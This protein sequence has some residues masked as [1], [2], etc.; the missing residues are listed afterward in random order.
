MR[1][2]LFHAVGA[3]RTHAVPLVLPRRPPHLAKRSNRS[4][5]FRDPTTKLGRCMIGSGTRRKLDHA[6]FRPDA[7]SRALVTLFCHS[8]EF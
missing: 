7:I 2:V 3:R 5:V 8:S 1:G 6:P 4:L